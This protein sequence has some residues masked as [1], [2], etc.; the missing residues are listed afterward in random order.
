MLHIS[1]FKKQKHTEHKE[2]KQLKIKM[3]YVSRQQNSIDFH[4]NLH[5]YFLMP[6]QLSYIS[7][8]EYTG[9]QSNYQF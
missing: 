2:D 8:A 7:P 3:W 6:P 4:S 1:A 9:P 5:L